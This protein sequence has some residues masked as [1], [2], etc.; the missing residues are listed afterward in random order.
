MHSCVWIIPTITLLPKCAWGGG[1]RIWIE[2]SSQVEREI[3][4]LLCPLLIVPDWDF[5]KPRDREEGGRRKKRKKAVC[6]HILGCP[7][8]LQADIRNDKNGNS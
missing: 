8:T 7:V 1:V 4:Q 5:S 2:E 6:S 3:P